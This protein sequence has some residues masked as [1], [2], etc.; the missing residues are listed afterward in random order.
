[1]HSVVK[2]KTNHT[3]QIEK[4]RKKR[5][6]YV[7]NQSWKTLQ[8]V[9]ETSVR[10]HRNETAHSCGKSRGK[11]GSGKSSDTNIKCWPCFNGMPMNGLRK[12][13]C[14]RQLSDISFWKPE[15][16]KEGRAVRNKESLCTETWMFVS[17]GQLLASGL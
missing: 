15:A 17:R 13:Q 2:L 7:E 16:D 3:K 6:K 1:M 10:K 4:N 5:N 11:R 9:Y 14:K 8:C 12:W